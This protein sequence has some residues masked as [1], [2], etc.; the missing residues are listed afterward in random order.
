M[1]IEDRYLQLVC[2]E[3]KV[4]VNDVRSKRR[5][6][7]L[8]E[9]RQVTSYVL[10]K[11]TKMSLWSIARFMNYVSHASPLRDKKQVPSLLQCDKKFAAKM[12]P[13]IDKASELAKEIRAIELENKRQEEYD[14]IFSYLR[15][16]DWY[17]NVFYA[18]SLMLPV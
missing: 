5:L 13:V 14:R 18:E 10:I 7:E 12:L 8:C 16:E 2:D 4:D 11:H 1:K 9:A 15:E 6:R 17:N 3:L